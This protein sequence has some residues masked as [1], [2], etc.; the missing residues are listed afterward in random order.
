[1]RFCVLL[2]VVMTVA[3]APAPFP[4]AERRGGRPVNEMVGTWKGTYGGQ[5]YWLEADGQS[6]PSYVQATFSNALM[7][8]W[9]RSGCTSPSTRR[10][11][12]WTTCGQAWS[13]RGSRLPSLMM[14]GRRSSSTRVAGSI[15]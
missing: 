7:W 4:R 1:M 9:A 12:A 5:G 6:V 13:E 3:F 8:T 2:F 15:L 14:V 11:R 10:R